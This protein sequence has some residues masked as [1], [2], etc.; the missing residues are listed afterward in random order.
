MY[1]SYSM[2]LAGRTLTV[3][4]G[5]VAAQANGAALMHYGDTVVLS[6]ATASDKPRE[7]IDFFPLSVEYSEKLYA[8]GK[9]P[10]GFI[11][12]EG[13]PSENA[14]LTSRVIDRPMRPL[15]PSDY[16]NDVTLEN[17]VLC[18]DQDCPPEL[19]AML[20]SSIATCISDIPFAGPVA[21][22]MV[23]LVDGEFVFNPNS[24]QREKSDLA[25]TVASTK[26]KVIMIEAG[27]NEIPEDK[28]I[29][30]IYAAHEVNKT[31][32][33]FIDKIVEECGKEKHDYIKFEVDK[34]L[35]EDM[36]GFITPEGMEKAVFTDEKQVRE[37]NI[38][39]IKE[40]LVARYEEEHPEWLEQLDEAIYKFQ[41]HCP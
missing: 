38:K 19:A 41:K 21:S 11:K 37:A 1:K 6:T 26:E 10:G 29:E 18:V 33:E 35:Y 4:I 34:D 8:V 39:E 27:A 17:L 5:R 32:I 14:I 15:F 25:L 7:G 13:K 3:E 40:K 28:M 12:R 16:R 31:I 24:E 22:T 20:G 9:I 23:G 2:E 30:A 36:V